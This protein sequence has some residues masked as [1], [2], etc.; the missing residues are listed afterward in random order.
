MPALHAD[1]ADPAARVA[2][3]VNFVLAREYVLRTHGQAVW[4]RVLAGLDAGYRPVWTSPVT[5]GTYDFAAFK[6]MVAVLAD[7]TRVRDQGALSAMYAFIAEQS[8]SSLYKVFFR[9]ANPSFVIGNFP[10]LWSR[11]FTAGEVRVPEARRERAQLVFD[12]PEIFLDWLGPACLGYSTKAVELAGGR[13]V[14][15]RESG[16]EA[17]GGGA[18]RVTFLVTWREGE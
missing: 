11:F 4:E 18:W 14:Q 17:L 6:A 8:L 9:L 16:R 7:V 3:G 5:V 15:V 2:R 1:P 12:V 13:G 10:K